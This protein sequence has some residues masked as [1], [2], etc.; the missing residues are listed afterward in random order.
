MNTKP[1]AH[2]V[3]STHWDREWYET[4]QD[5]RRRLVRL[6]DRVLDSI[7]DGSLRG[8]FTTDGQWIILE[9]YLEIRPERRQ[10]VE[11]AVR[12]G[13]FVVGPWF[14][15]PDEWLVS[16]ESLVRNLRYGREMVRRQGVEPSSAGFV[17]DMFGHIGQL[18]QILSQFG[19][20]GALVWRGVEDRAKAH[21]HWRG[22][23]GT[24]LPCYR[25]GRTGYCD[26]SVDVRHIL[27]H[28]IAFDAD[29][30]SKDVQNFLA[31]EAARSAIPPL[32]IFDGADH[33]EYDD[34]QYRQ[35]FKLQDGGQLTHDVQ[36]STLDQ[37]IEEMLAH[38]DKITDS[39]S[40]ELRETGVNPIQDDAQWLIP[41]TL[42]SRVWIKQ[43]NAA[44]Q[45]L[46]CQWVE[47]LATLATQRLGVDYP[48]QYL[49]IAWRWLLLNHPH[50]SMCGCSI[51]QVHE[52]MKYRFSQ[53]QQIGTGQATESLRLLGQA[54]GGSINKGEV[55][56][57][58][59]NPLPAE[60]DEIYELTLDIP[61]EWATYQEFFGFETK[62]GF[63][64]FYA[65]SDVEIAYQLL[66][67][68]PVRTRTRIWSTKFPENYKVQEVRVAVRL[69][70]PPIGYTTLTVR[71]GKKVAKLLGFPESAHATR[72]PLAP[73][74][75]TSDCSMENEFLSIRILANGSIDITD[76]RNGSE[77]KRL[78]TFEDAADIGDGWYHGP[79]VNDQQI[80]TS[81]SHAEVRLETD[82][83][84]QCTFRVRT[85]LRVPEEFTADRRRRSSVFVDMVCDSTL[86]LRAGSDRLEVMTMIDNKARDHRMRVLLPSG[87]KAETYVSDGAFDVIERKIALPVDNHLKREISVETTPQQ[88]WTALTDGQ[89]G[90]AVVAEGLHECT[91]RDLPE[92]PIA[93][94]LFRSTRRTVFTDGEPNGQLLGPLQFKYWIVPFI[95]EVPRA[96]LCYLGQQLS[97][98]V[99][100]AQLHANDLIS[101]PRPTRPA[102]LRDSLLRVEGDVVCTSVRQIAS[103]IELRVFN[104]GE[105]E[106]TFTV[107]LEDD[108]LS[109]AARLTPVDFESNIVGD[110]LSLSESLLIPPKSIKTYQI[111]IPA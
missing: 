104:P 19:V 23:D 95:G 71:E 100:V 52:D 26:Y 94:T 106:V 21:F 45:T 86:T 13:R 111:S 55:R 96:R 75:A 16:G 109:R 69:N 9:D 4:F 24:Q 22:S 34:V 65:D 78:L 66:E 51:D 31:K 99:R 30:S 54:I 76:K 32:L 87:V 18:P 101:T 73:G 7:A 25:F 67:L 35:L 108:A 41:G 5:F 80:T 3:L 83:P 28:E 49:E 15:M 12:T 62:P 47:P 91:V 70:L 92:R 110:D 14:V 82:G 48:H 74:L 103:H 58:V 59:A 8:P 40:G 60:T 63:R 36:H 105:R 11:D 42:A 39:V 72:F 44:C 53:C 29:Q 85:Y 6:L 84:Q 68:T 17:C 81:A 98:D 10:E 2:Y 37:Y 61:V 46:L 38:D 56:V 27:E 43:Q 33:Q 64:I 50:D 77:Y 93:L 79:P 97:A 57:L 1:R 88:T 89:R 90:L 102:R 107:A 20:K